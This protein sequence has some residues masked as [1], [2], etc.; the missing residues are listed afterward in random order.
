MSAIHLF[1]LRIYINF[2]YLYLSNSYIKCGTA[3]IHFVAGIENPQMNL[4][5]RICSETDTPAKTFKGRK[6]QP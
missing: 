2:I 6:P 3:S 4:R 1:V 5:G